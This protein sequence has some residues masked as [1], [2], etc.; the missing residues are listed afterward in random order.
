M[1]G[2]TPTDV[3]KPKTDV[4]VRLINFID[5]GI[6]VDPIG[7]YFASPEVLA[8]L[9]TADIVVS[10]VDR[11]SVRAEINTFC[12]RYDIPLIDVGLVIK[13][14]DDRLVR[15]DGQLPLAVPDTASLRCRPLLSDS[16]L[17]RGR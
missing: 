13:T 15:A 2:S 6:R 1:I 17:D 8:A 14:K 3:G 4:M 16:V 11:F 10:C 12:R 9:K 7:D 5:P